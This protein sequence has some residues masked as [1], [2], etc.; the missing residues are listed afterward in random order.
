[1][2]EMMMMMI[3]RNKGNLTL[4]GVSNKSSIRQVL[5]PPL[6]CD[7]KRR[8]PLFNKR[9]FLFRNPFSVFKFWSRPLLWKGSLVQAACMLHL[10]WRTKA[11]LAIV[12]TQFVFSFFYCFSPTS[13]ILRKVKFCLASYFGITRRNIKKIIF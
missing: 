11:K 10:W 3:D 8:Q 4:G 13:G 7:E 1:M 12:F 9:F 6:S 2:K 5:P